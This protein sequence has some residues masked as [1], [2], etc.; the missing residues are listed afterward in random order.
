MYMY[1]PVLCVGHNVH[2]CASTVCRGQ[3]TCMLKDIKFLGLPN[4]FH[5][6]IRAWDRHKSQH[7]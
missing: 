5:S 2:V 6:Y 7:T 4:V 3:C 1:V